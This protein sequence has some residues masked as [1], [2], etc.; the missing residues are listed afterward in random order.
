[1]ST[2]QP[3][4]LADERIGVRSKI[5]ALWVA[6]LLLFAYGDILGFFAP[7]RIDEVLSGE[8]SGMRITQS[9]LFAVSVYIEVA[10]VMVVLS[11]VLSPRTC[12][13]ASLVLAALY[14]VS[15]VASS[16]GEDA[17]FLFLSVVESA[18]LVLIIWF[19]WAWPTPEVSGE[20]PDRLDR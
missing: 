16:I 6:V 19:A 13:W 2:S 9:F 5:S 14:I 17:Y 18:L 1:M 3:R 4:S 7:G 11:L 12:R 15:I 20:V 8:V 10:A